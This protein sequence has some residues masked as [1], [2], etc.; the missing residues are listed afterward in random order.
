MYFKLANEFVNYFQIA[1][2]NCCDSRNLRQRLESRCDVLQFLKIMKS[3][4]KKAW[5]AVI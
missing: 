3:K 5:G 2:N 1:E 4:N